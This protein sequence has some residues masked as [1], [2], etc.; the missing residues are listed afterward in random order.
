MKLKLFLILIITLIPGISRAQVPD[1]YTGSV[2]VENQSPAAREDAFP[3]AL[4]QV[5]GKLSGLRNLDQNPEIVDAVE[6]ARSLVISFHYEQVERMDD[7]A[8][9]S[10]EVPSGQTLLA[11][12]FSQPGTDELVKAM[13][14]PRWRAER[15]PLLVWLLIDDGLGRQVMPLE[16]QYL[17]NPLD[18]AATNRGLKLQWPQAD[19]EGNYAVDV[20]LLWGGYTEQPE[21]ETDSQNV[22]IIAARRE[23]PE[24]STRQIL[25]YGGENWSWRSQ[26]INLEQ[27]LTEAVNV[28]VDEISA[29]QAISASEQ[30]SWIHRITVGGL[31]S[32]DDYIRCLEYLE[33]LSVVDEVAVAAA[34]PLAVSMVLV[35]NAAPE[36]FQ[37]VLKGDAVLESEDG[38]SHYVLQP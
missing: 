26:N 4:I 7:D 32:G 16:Y 31:A 22:L 24:W 18:R 3:L 8:G 25:N 21:N 15:A 9:A 28:V 11:V 20:Q 2:P 38:S 33:S 17:R 27:G 5:L 1:L 12:R 14:L 35:L 23:G 29:V 13:Q 37:Q 34:D 19:E 30:G 36:Y 6:Y 10:Q